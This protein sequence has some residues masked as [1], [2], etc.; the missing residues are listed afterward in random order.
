MT[1]YTKKKRVIS[2]ITGLIS[3][4]LNVVPVVVFVIIGFIQ[5]GVKEKI[6]LSFIGI[7][8]LILGLLM[9]IAKCSLKRTLFWITMIGIY[10][11]LDKLSSVI[12]TMAVCNILDE[13]I[14][15]P[16]H[17]KFANDYKINKEIDKRQE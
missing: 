11:C 4:L 16:I 1:E 9:L 12:I 2:R 3:L 5:G 10:I 14:V 17:K 15:S 13:V 6:T 8:A 7:S